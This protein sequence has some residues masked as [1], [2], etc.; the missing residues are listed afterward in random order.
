[1]CVVVVCTTFKTYTNK[2]HMTTVAV[3]KQGGPMWQYTNKGGHCGST[4]TRGTNVTIHKQGGPLWQYTNKGDQCGN[5]QTR[6]ATVA[7]HK[8][9]GPLWQ[10]TNKSATVAIY[11]QGGHCGNKHY[12]SH[13]VQFSN[14]QR[15]IPS[16]P[17]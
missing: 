8:Q 17:Y 12:I 15:A 3:H 13:S 14:H 2:G 4:Q 1:M 5:T 10:Y 7:I 11:K 9:G 16:V 6:G